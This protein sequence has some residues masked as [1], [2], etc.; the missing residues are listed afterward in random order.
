MLEKWKANQSSFVQPLNQLYG[1]FCL[2]ASEVERQLSMQVHALREDFREKNSSTNQHIIR[3]ESLQAEV[4]RPVQQ[5][6]DGS[7]FL[8]GAAVPGLLD[9]EPSEQKPA[10]SKISR[11]TY[12]WETKWGTLDH[13]PPGS[14]LSRKI[15][16][17]RV[18]AECVEIMNALLFT[19][20]VDPSKNIH[21]NP[22]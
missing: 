1:L 13:V 10:L 8:I 3:L 7:A 18:T 11:E 16:L 21:A 22:K 4:S 9:K 6:L 12:L 5:C 14:L 15:R 17:L 19:E 2:Q 20:Y